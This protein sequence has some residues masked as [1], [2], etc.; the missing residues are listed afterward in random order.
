MNLFRSTRAR[1]VAGVTALLVAGSFGMAAASSQSN[2]SGD[3]MSN[4]KDAGTGVDE[5]GLTRANFDGKTL[6]F[7]YTK[8]FF[9]DTSVAA[10]SSSGCEVGEKFQEAP[11]A[12]FDPLYVLV[13]LGFD[14]PSMSMECPAGL[15]CVDHP[16][17]L[18]LTRIE[19]ALK[20][21]Y[22]NLTDEQLT[23][24]L[25]N[26]D[27]PGHDHFITDT[28][29]GRPEWWDVRVVGVTDEDEYHKI[30]AH[31]SASY[32][33]KQVKA[34]RTTPVLKSNLFLFFSVR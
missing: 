9:C 16:G 24:A 28:N 19:P 20:P 23:E 17:T 22:P 13:P 14:L 10:Q 5:F 30:V 27:T 18:D 32:L 21:L 6:N 4:A 31:K 11:A 7:R 34:G 1:F 2:M 15:V 25:K 29:N 12:H 8:G 3:P 26:F 33:L